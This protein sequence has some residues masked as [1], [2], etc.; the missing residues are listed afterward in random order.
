MRSTKFT[1]TVLDFRPSA[2]SKA[3]ETLVYKEEY[4]AMHGFHKA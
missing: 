4:T 2:E 1:C 3:A